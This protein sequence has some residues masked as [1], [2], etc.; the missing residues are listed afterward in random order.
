M[1]NSEMPETQKLAGALMGLSDTPPSFLN[2][3]VLTDEE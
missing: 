2:L 3:D 1:E